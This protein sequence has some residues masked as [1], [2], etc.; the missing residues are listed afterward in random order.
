MKKALMQAAATKTLSS[1]AMQLPAP[2]HKADAEK[3]FDEKL[4]S[5]AYEF[6]K[7]VVK[8]HFHRAM[9]EAGTYIVGKFFDGDF[10][11]AKNPR[12]ATKI[13]SLNELIRRLQGNDGHGPSKTWV[14]NAVKLAV[15]ERQLRGFS[16]YGKLGLSH[17]V[18]LTHVKNP[19]SKRQLIQEAVEN[20]YTVAQTRSRIAEIQKNG[21]R[22]KV[23]L[24]D[25]PAYEDLEIVGRDEL[26]RLKQEALYKIEFHKDRLAFYEGRLNSITKALKS[27][28]S[29]R[30]ALP[31]HA[32]VIELSPREATDTDKHER[33]REQGV[34]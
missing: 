33:K 28:A 11:R 12:N 13:H 14:Y 8:R 26:L 7:G 25:L 22:E 10:E 1:S 21:Q 2:A 16:V 32:N 20:N 29:R 27:I 9:L 31:D 6:L 17:K 34:I 23:S 18:Y 19:D 3:G 30:N 4:V 24:S 5:G 15:D